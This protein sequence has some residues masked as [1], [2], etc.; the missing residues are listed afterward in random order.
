[1][2]TESIYRYPI[3]RARAFAILLL[4]DDEY[5]SMAIIIEGLFVMLLIIKSR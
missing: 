3:V 1:M 5:P 4:P 2:A